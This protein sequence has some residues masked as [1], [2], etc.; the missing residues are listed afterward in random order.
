MEKMKKVLSQF[1]LF[2]AVLGLLAACGGA[3]ADSDTDKTEIVVGTSPGPYSELFIDAIIPILEEEGFIVETQTFSELLQADVALQEG[4]IDVNVDQHTAYYTN[5]NEERDANLT[6]ITPIP[7]VATGI[8]GGRK[9]NLEDLA[10]GDIIAVPQD[11]SNAARAYALLEKAGIIEVEEGVEFMDVTKEKI[12]TY[13]VDV[14]IKE[15]D[16]AQIP[17]SLQDI[18]YGVIPGSIVFAAGIDAA[19]SLLDEDILKELELVAVVDEKNKD[20][21]WAQAIKD[22]YQSDEFKAYLDE[23]NKDGYWFIPEELQ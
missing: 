20:S 12:A 14:D 1:V 21:K 23:H 8:Y 18:D 15:I 2:F 17:P 19:T 9:D 22:A 7:T 3:K 6:G 4:A 13:H 11:P 5:F 10:D 16:S